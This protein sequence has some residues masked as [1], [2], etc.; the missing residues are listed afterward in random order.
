MNQQTLVSGKKGFLQIDVEVNLFFGPFRFKHDN[1]LP[2][3][4]VQTKSGRLCLDCLIIHLG[5][6]QNISHQ[7]GQ[8]LGVQQNLVDIFPLFRAILRNPLHQHGVS[9][10]GIQRRFKFVGYVRYKVG[11]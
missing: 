7:F 2:H 5:Q 6:Q 11:L 10:N 1:R 4:L 9:F 8:T 3:L